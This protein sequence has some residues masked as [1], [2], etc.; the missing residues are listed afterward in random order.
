LPRSA[1]GVAATGRPQ[2]AVVADIADGKVETRLTPQLA[3]MKTLNRLEQVNGGLVKLTD[4]V[5]RVG[6]IA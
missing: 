5:F 4:G 1:P 2:R 3:G 6:S